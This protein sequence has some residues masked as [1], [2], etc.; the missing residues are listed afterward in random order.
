MIIDRNVRIVV[1]GAGQMAN[2]VHY[3]SLAGSEDVEIVGVV[4]TRAEPLRATCDRWGIQEG[5]RHLVADPTGY[6]AVLQALRPDGVYAIGQP[7]VMLPIWLWCLQNGFN[8]F[9]EKPMGFTVHQAEMLAHLAQ[10]DGAITQV[11]HQRRSAPIMVEMKKRLMREGPI[12]HGVVE[13]FKC[14]PTP[15]VNARDRMLDDGTHAVD[16]ARWICGGEVVRVESECRR[17]ATPDIN[18]FNAM[19]HFDNGA[20]CLV[21]CNWASGRRVFRAQMHAFRGYADVEIEHDARL[22]LDG[23]YEGEHIHTGQVAG[24]DDFHVLGGF[25]AKTREFIDS[26]R[27]GEDVCTS[28]FRDAVKTM[29]VCYA[30]LGQALAS[31]V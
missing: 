1:I 27:T 22:F 7:D 21:A 26:L 23:D 18:F 11:G 16:T 8:L 9:I 20:T 30:I 5:A 15:M 29:R 31:G 2:R 3:P 13:F 14:D 24:S 6:Q 4:E 25:K 28:P 12:L 19:L 17:I 10:T